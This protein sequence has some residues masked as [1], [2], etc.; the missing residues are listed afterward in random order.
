MKQVKVW[1]ENTEA[2]KWVR[3]NENGGN[4]Y[5]MVPAQRKFIGRCEATAEAVAELAGVDVDVATEALALPGEPVF[6]GEFSPQS[7][8]VNFYLVVTYSAQ[9]RTR[10]RK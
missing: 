6:I 7:L 1:L 8:V 5:A 2:I 10:G 3:R 4:V 9:K